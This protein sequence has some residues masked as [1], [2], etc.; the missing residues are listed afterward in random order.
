MSA[1][2]MFILQIMD[3]RTI[4]VPLTWYPR[5]LKATADQRSKWEKCGGNYGIHW[6]EIDEDLS[7]EG[8]LLKD[9]KS[10]WH[11]PQYLRWREILRHY[12]LEG[13]WEMN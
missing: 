5:L 4:T 10:R 11:P 3:G 8:L 13:P 9:K 12:F 2:A 1:L 7:I 6:P